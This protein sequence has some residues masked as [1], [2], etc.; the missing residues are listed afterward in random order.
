MNGI[1][2]MQ[3]ILNGDAFAHDGITTVASLLEIKEIKGGRVAVMVNDE[4][5]KKQWFTST[6]IHEG[7]RVEIVHMVGGG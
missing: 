4:I 2:I 5:V 7:D 3:I 6:A 1:Q